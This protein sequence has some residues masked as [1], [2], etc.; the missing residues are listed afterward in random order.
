MQGR[1]S[2]PC[3]DRIQA[4]PVESWAAEFD[5]ARDAGLACIE[6]IYESGTDGANPLG[7]DPGVAAIRQCVARTGVRVSSVCADYYMAHRLVSDGGRP[8]P[9]AIAHL[10]WLIG[11]AALVEARYVVLPFVDSSSLRSEAERAALIP[12]LRQLLAAAERAHVE[13]HLETDFEPAALR[14]T[15]DRIDHSRVKANYDIGNSASLGHDPDDELRQIG[16]S[17]GSVHVKDR[18]R[19]S[20]TVPLGTGDA[21]FAICFRHFKALG[22]PGPYILQAARGDT[23]GEV[24]L[25]HRNREFTERWCRA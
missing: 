25:A 4:F 24:T 14:A 17:L 9:D 16:A 12:V 1:L 20:A 6:W 10:D 23:G 3:G 18:R 15:L 7:T 21:D 22:F 19:G 13:L 2:P 11:R 8:E 5:A